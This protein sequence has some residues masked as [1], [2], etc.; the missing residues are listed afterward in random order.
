M[1]ELKS[2]RRRIAKEQAQ[3]HGKSGK[4]YSEALRRE[5]SKYLQSATA[6]G[7][8]PNQLAPELGVSVP[9]AYQWTARQR[10]RA[11]KENGQVFRQ[12]S[13]VA[14]PSNGTRE[15]A[16]A[17]SRIVVSGPGGLRAVGLAVADLA[18]LLRRLGC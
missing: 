2:L 1:D 4:P 8:S 16:S 15:T 9:T 11:R 17:S 5:V 10:G 12:M 3:G 13:I 6:D 18:E 14:Q 7:R